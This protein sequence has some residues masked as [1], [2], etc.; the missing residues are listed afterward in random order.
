MARPRRATEAVLPGRRAL[1]ATL[2]LTLTPWPS[3]PRPSRAAAP[4]PAVQFID[5]LGNQVL[6]VLRDDRLERSARLERLTGLLDQA[7]DLTL[8]SRLVLG[9]YWREA[10]EPQRREYTALFRSLVLKTM[11]D[12][13]ESYGGETYEVLSSQPVDDRD[14][15]VSTRIKRP[16]TAT[17]VAVDWRVREQG[18]RLLIIDIIAE[19]V[20]M[21][22]TQRSEA[23]E[24]AGRAGLDGLLEEMRRRLSRPA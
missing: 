6:E 12:R 1:L 19:G 10:S 11:A 17:M 8:V 21:V 14:T 23:A 3:G 2:L 16:G 13:L 20:S 9:R 22:V 7:T 5:R 18:G 24:I 4:V 15:I